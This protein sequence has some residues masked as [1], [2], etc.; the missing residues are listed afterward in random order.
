ME[1]S[2][3]Q[4]KAQIRRCHPSTILT[5]TPSIC[6]TFLSRKSFR[7]ANRTFR[8]CHRLSKHNGCRLS[9]TQEVFEAAGVIEIGRGILGLGTG[10]GILAAL[11]WSGL[12]VI[13]ASSGGKKRDNV[14]EEDAIGVKWGVMT[15]LSFLPL[16][17]WLVRYLP[18]LTLACLPVSKLL[19]F[20]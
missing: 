20:H 9:A 8:S 14:D 15:V 13:S 11:T 18:T 1:I 5:Q 2:L 3:P 19:H 10:V 4:T 16:F 6:K 12:P 17:N 7:H